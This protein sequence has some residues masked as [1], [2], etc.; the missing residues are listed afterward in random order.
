MKFV[1]PTEVYSRVAGYFR[2]VGN[3]NRGKKEEFKQ[4]LPYSLDKIS[5]AKDGE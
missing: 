2:P 1:I 4:R 5:E 3:W